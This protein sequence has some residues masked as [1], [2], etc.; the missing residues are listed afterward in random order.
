ILNKMVRTIRIDKVPLQTIGKILS[1]IFDVKYTLLE[2]DTLLIIEREDKIVER[3]HYLSIKAYPKEETDEIIYNIEAKEGVLLPRNLKK[4]N[5]IVRFE[6]L[7]NLYVTWPSDLKKEDKKITFLT[8]FKDRFVLLD[9]DYLLK[10]LIMVGKNRRKEEVE[11][12]EEEKRRDFKL[13]KPGAL[14][15]GEKN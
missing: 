14:E 7:E 12:V 4:Y 6:E 2:N 5:N 8:I 11:K 10:S 15:K 3:C 9:I 1:S 13:V